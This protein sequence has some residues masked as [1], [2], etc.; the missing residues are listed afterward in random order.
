MARSQLVIDELW[1]LVKPLL[2]DCAPQRTGRLQV[3]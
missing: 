2:P 3:S 1:E